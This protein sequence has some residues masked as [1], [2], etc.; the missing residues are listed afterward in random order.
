MINSFAESPERDS[1]KEK[2]RRSDI[3]NHQ[4]PLRETLKG[5]CGKS[6]LQQSLLKGTLQKKKFRRSDISNHQSPLRETLK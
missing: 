2:F 6:T 1:A 4:S 5:L 3:S